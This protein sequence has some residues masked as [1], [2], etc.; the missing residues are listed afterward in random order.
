MGITFLQF[1][2]YL[3]DSAIKG[4]NTYTQKKESQ[5]EQHL[6]LIKNTQIKNCISGMLRLDEAERFT[7]VEAINVLKNT[8]KTIEM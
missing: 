3:E 6:N 8:D 7:W 1:V 4:L 2:R 5:I